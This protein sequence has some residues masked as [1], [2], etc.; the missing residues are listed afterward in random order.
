MTRS[1]YGDSG[2][3]SKGSVVA[4]AFRLEGQDFVA[5]NGGPHFKLNEAVSFYVNC[6]T[7]P[8]IDALWDRLL[9]GGGE[10]QACGWLK[11]RFGLSW[12]IN[13]A[14][15]QDMMTDTR[16]ERADR[17]MQTLLKMKKVDIQRLKD[18]YEEGR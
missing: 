9:S 5:I 2:R 8:E 18:A 3:G 12:Q 17:V 7:Q 6:E 16:P 14:G 4:I 13:Y 15:L 1:R 10:V 11:D